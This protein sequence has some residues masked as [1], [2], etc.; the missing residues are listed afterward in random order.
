MRKNTPAEALA[1]KMRKRAAQREVRRNY[2]PEQIEKRKLYLRARYQTYEAVR[3]KRKREG[4][5]SHAQ[6]VYGPYWQ[7]AL[8]LRDELRRLKRMWAMKQLEE[9]GE[10]IPLPFGEEQ[11]LNVGIK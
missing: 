5:L 6:R 9:S 3:R 1:A 10:P 8:A 7:K 2:T 4:R 11:I